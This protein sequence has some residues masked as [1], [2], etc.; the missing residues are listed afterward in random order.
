MKTLIRTYGDDIY[1][2]DGKTPA[3]LQ[4][5]VETLDFVEMPNGSIINKKSISAY[6]TYEDYQFQTDQKIRHKK[7]QY[8][9]H[10][11]WNDSQGEIAN[12]DLER[13]TGQITKSLLIK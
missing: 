10:G 1:I 5:M 8:L 11:N 4:Q 13:I 9:K 6:Q 3:E 12:A 7:G 2:I